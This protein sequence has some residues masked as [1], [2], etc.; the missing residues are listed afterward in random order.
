MKKPDRIAL[1]SLT[2]FWEIQSESF[3][4]FALD[5]SEVY[6]SCDTTVIPGVTSHNYTIKTEYESSRNGRLEGQWGRI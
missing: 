5:G 2:A 6:V 4:V 3:D 1:K